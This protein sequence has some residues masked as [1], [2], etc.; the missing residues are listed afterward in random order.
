[1][2]EKARILYYD[3]ETTDLDA[4]FGNMLAFGYK[5]AG[6]RKAHVISLLDTN[7]VCQGCGHVDAVSDKKLVK[8]AHAILTQA[9]MWVTWY[10]KGFDD[11]FV[12]TRVLD[13][14]LKPLPPVPHVD[15]YFTAKHRLKLSSN[16]LASVQDFLQLPTSKTPLTKRI[17]RKA[18][19]GHVPSI[20]YIVDHCQK[21]VMVLEEA[22]ERLKPLIRSHPRV[23]DLGTCPTCGSSRL[24]RRGSYVRRNRELRRQVIEWRVQCQGCG[25]WATQR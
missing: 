24:Q 1:M 21:D 18:Q 12:N 9:D 6:D 11:K 2:N 10:G 19:A 25:S 23:G 3:I 14:K 16:R 5:W 4:D 8:A 13:A 22:Y 20:R 15:L 7:K 17:W